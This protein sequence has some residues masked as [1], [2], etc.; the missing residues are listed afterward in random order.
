VAEAQFLMRYDVAAQ[1]WAQPGLP[2][3]LRRFD[4]RANGFRPT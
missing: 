2:V 1:L 3:A 4:G